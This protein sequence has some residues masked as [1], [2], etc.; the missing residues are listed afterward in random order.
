[1][2]VPALLIH[3]DDGGD[4]RQFFH[5]KGDMR[6][7]GDGA[8]P[9]LEIKR[10]EKFFRLLLADLAQRL[11]H[12]ERR[13]RILGHGVGLHLGLDTVDGV[14]IGGGGLGIVVAGHEKSMLAGL[15]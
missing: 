2:A 15:G 3:Q 6:Q 4:H 14:D 10:V 9:V 7:V 8:V 12:R 13:A 1:M 11:F 5:G